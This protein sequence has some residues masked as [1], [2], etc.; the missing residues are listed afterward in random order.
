VQTGIGRTGTFLA[1][2]QIGLEPDA[3]PLSKAVAGGVPMGAC[4][5]R[6]RARDVFV[7]GDH[8]STFAGNPL[9][10]AAGLA[11]LREVANERFL[12]R[13]ERAGERVRQTISA[14][15]LPFVT[16]VRG[17]GLMIGIDVDP[18]AMKTPRNAGEIQKLC[19]DAG[20]CI[21]TAGPNTIRFLPPLVITDDE[22]DAGLDIFKAVLD[23]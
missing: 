14:W 7:A 2:E 18:G 15:N 20:L 1:S 12:R 3:V 8:Q 22:L 16:D 21:T 13:V 9:A 19:L 23:G 10:C 17:R 5:F 6:G 4:L 11:V